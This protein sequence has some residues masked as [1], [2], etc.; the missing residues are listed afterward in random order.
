MLNIAF[1]AE[2]SSLARDSL[3]SPVQIAVSLLVGVLSAD[4]RAINIFAR[5]VAS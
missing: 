5:N 1:P 2:S 4:S 3:A